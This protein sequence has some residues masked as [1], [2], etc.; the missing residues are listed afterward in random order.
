M[1]FIE[2][3]EAVIQAT[4]FHSRM[5]FS[6]FG[7]LSPHL[8]PSARRALTPQIE[9]KCLL[10]NLQFQLYKDFYCRG[11]PN[12]AEQELID[13]QDVG[14]TSFVRQLSVANAGKGYC[15]DG[16]SVHTV[17]GCNVAVRRAGLELWAR[18]RDCLIPP[19]IL[20]EPGMRLGLRF[21]KELF[22]ISPGFYV[23]MGDKEL[24]GDNSQALVRV[25]WNLTAEGSV[26]FM[27]E[28]TLTLNGAELPFKIKAVNDP[29]RFTRRDAVVLYIRKAD[30][31]HVSELMER[32]YPQLVPSLKKG[33]PAFTKQLATGVGLAED[34]GQGESFGA[35]RCRILAEGLIRA[36]EQ[37]RRSV[38]EKLK[39]I[40]D[41]FE[42]NGIDLS[43]P[44]LASAAVDDYDFHL[45]FE[46]M[47]HPRPSLIPGSASGAF[48]KTAVQIGESLVQNAVWYEG[49]CNWMGTANDEPKSAAVSLTRKY[50]P[51]GSLL[52][53]GTSGVAV[54]L[55]ELHSVNAHRGVRR[56]AIGAIEHA[57]SYV[58]VKPELPW[59]VYTGWIGV[60]LAAAWVGKALR[61]DDLLERAARMLRSFGSVARTRSEFDFI[62]GNAGV[63]TA[64]I[65]LRD[66]LEDDSFLDL[67]TELGD[68]LLRSA[69]RSNVGL[70]WRS[71]LGSGG[72]NLTGFAHGSAGAGF[73]LLELF[74]LT[75]R[76]KYLE[77]A[78]HA[79]SY[80]RHWFDSK[81]GNWPDFREEQGKSNRR[82]SRFSNAWCH[83]APGVALSRLRAY[84]VTKNPK[85]KLEAMI[86]LET[87]HRITNVWVQSGTY[88]YSLCHGLSGNAEILFY[89][90]QVLGNDFA[91]GLAT[92]H[93]VA[94]ARIA[95]S[96][97]SSELTDR[98][99]DESE[100]PGLMLG[101]AGVGYF[102]LRL[103]NPTSRSVLSLVTAP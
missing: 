78:D 49:V 7:K 16:W 55:A 95:N 80:E 74:R 42:E 46:T 39:V 67:A 63:I 26:R 83:G 73:A 30:Y 25:Y 47:A 10:Y 11:F 75:N 69:E 32:I 27:R 21:P 38:Q 90:W 56:C 81:V 84:E 13:G 3:V 52:Y 43:K 19:G 45:R 59:G 93:A 98:G 72:R 60:A 66:L 94:H 5:T 28:A 2:Q 71:P 18:P 48:L 24:V 97:K 12:P 51:L 1:N 29:A 99:G 92:A 103:H 57:L 20:I 89:G 22:S 50:C 34:P 44:F 100:P 85:Y 53:S 35:H 33:E 41:C 9:R 77:A 62:S 86:A 70:S 8:H 15:S 58:D 6:W 40:K 87:T 68:D 36:R 88:N 31:R 102:F 14:V 76:A 4:T 37:R 65:L 82:P 79:F 101:L 23:A 61:R 64:F 54:F 17:R 91:E 96:T